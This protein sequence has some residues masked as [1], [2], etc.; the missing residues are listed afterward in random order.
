MRRYKAEEKEEIMKKYLEGQS[1]ASISRETTIHENVL[2]RWKRQ[3]MIDQNGEMDREK[4]MMRKKIR[5]LEM[6]IDVLKKT[7]IIFAR[8]S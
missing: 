1:I 4:I 6:E 7:A 2:R 8:G 5:Q 3:L